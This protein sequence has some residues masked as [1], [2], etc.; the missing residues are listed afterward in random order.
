MLETYI[1]V[2]CLE[3][4]KGEDVDEGKGENLCFKGIP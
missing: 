3:E 2:L 1:F 4:R